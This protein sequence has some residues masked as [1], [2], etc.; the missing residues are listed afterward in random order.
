[1]DCLAGPRRSNRF[2]RLGKS[3]RISVDW[4][5]G[6]CRTACSW[7]IGRR[8][9]DGFDRSDAFWHEPRILVHQW[10]TAERPAMRRL[11]SQILLSSRILRYRIH[12]FGNSEILVFQIRALPKISL[13]RRMHILCTSTKPTRQIGN[14]FAHVMPVTCQMATS[15]VSQFI[16]IVHTL[17]YKF[18]EEN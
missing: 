12:I 18:N 2:W 13:V 3:W 4:Q 6:L 15:T 7:G 8:R 11:W 5:R 17:N 10:R 14:A 1:M 9:F 16:F